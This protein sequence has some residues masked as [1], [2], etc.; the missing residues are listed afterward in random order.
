[1]DVRTCRTDHRSRVDTRV[2]QLFGARTNDVHQKMRRGTTRIVCVRDRTMYAREMKNKKPTTPIEITNIIIIVIRSTFPTSV[3]PFNRAHN[4]REHDRTEHGKSSRPFPSKSASQAI[5][6]AAK[7]RNKHVT[8]VFA[9]P[10]HTHR[11]DFFASLFGTL[12]ATRAPTRTAP[13]T[14]PQLRCQL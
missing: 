12:V 14:R 1:M 5:E 7:T 11:P 9:H 10:R 8:K 3:S 6:H 4:N 13:P 2:V